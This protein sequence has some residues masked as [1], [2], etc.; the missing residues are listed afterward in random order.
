[1]KLRKSILTLL[2][3]VALPSSLVACAGADEEAVESDD[4]DLSAS[5][6]QVVGTISKGETKTVRYT[7]SP[8][9]RAYRF[10]AAA[11][12]KVD[13]WVRSV[14]GDARAYILRSD[15]GTLA[16]NNDAD[17]STTDAHLVRTIRTAGTYYLAFKENKAKDADFTVTMQGA[18]PLP[19]G[20]FVLSK[21]A[22]GTKPFHV[23]DAIAVSINGSEVSRTQVPGNAPL[24]P[25]Q[26]AARIGDKL[27]VDL[28]DVGGVCFD[29]DE[30]WLSGLGIS[31]VRVTPA[32]PMVCGTQASSTP[33][34]SIEFA[35]GSAPMVPGAEFEF[36]SESPKMLY[37]DLL[38]YFG[39]GEMS[40]PVGTFSINGRRRSNCNE[41]TGCTAW[42][43]VD[44]LKV[45]EH[46][47]LD[48]RQFD[49]THP[50]PIPSVGSAELVIRPNNTAIV[51]M[52][53]LPDALTIAC[54]PSSSPM[55]MSEPAQ[56]SCWRNAWGGNTYLYPAEGGL[57]PSDA[58][59]FK[60]WVYAD[61]SY[62]VL[63][64]IDPNDRSNDAK[65]LQQLAFAGKFNAR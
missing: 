17:D 22:A 41:M 26:F 2:L 18:A 5:A 23:D 12:E 7:K 38:R 8:K 31:P 49:K 9:Y 62:R 14:N 4:F 1:M 27:R 53:R 57:G 21:D 64:T 59:R 28:I 37:R 3:A 51:L 39:P 45:T 55:R 63:S 6:I 25:V 61:G 15:F 36:D 52:L 44:S 13:A 11:G 40:A 19:N 54:E 16:T 65:N 10:T 58:Y 24:G 48:P 60:A 46:S 30:I 50:I 33:F 35:I 20:T 29:S 32:I 47:F 34:R 56:F 42:G 43:A